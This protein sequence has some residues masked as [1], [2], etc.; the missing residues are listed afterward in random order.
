MPIKGVV[1]DGWIEAITDTEGRIER[2][3]YELCVLVSLADALRRREIYVAGGA[4]WR[5]PEEDLP[6]DFRLLLLTAQKNLRNCLIGHTSLP[7][8]PHRCLFHGF[9]P[10]L[11]SYLST[12]DP[13][14]LL[15]LRALGWRGLAWHDHRRRD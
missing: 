4:R 5:N 6:S 2:V 3:S 15:A 12:L 11:Y 8:N 1:P 14:G 9:P 10:F 13:S 7:R